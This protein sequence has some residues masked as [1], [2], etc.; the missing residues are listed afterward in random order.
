M[1]SGV[2]RAGLAAITISLS[3]LPTAAVVAG[4]MVHLAQNVGKGV[5]EPHQAPATG[6]SP[7]LS[8]NSPEQIRKAQTELRRLDCLN[9]RIDGKLGDQTREAVKKF[10]AM[11]KQPAGEVSITYELIANLAERGDNF[12]RP[13]RRFFGF[14]GRALPP[15]L[16][17][18]VRPG[19]VPPATARPPSS[20]LGH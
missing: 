2:W 8:V 5:S 19:P 4:G 1:H 13:P 14:G 7:P 9:G 12:C 10:W 17:P 15:V 6:A 16:I 20:E 3:T 11:A 18:G